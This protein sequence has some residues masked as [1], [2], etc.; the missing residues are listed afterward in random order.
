MRDEMVCRLSTELCLLLNLSANPNAE[1]E[2]V[3]KLLCAVIPTIIVAEC[4]SWQEIVHRMSTAATMRKYMISLPSTGNAT[5]ANV[6][7]TAGFFEDSG[8]L[9]H[10]QGLATR[11]PVLERALALVP[12]QSEITE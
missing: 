3:L 11:C 6:A 7:P 8:P 1:L 10:R 2:D 5:A 12:S 4:V 9:D